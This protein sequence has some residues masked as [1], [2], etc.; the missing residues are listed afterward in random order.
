MGGDGHDG[1]RTVA[2]ED[3]FGDPHGD[4]LPGERIHGIGAG[5]HARHRLAG[6]AFA[7]GLLF[8]LLQIGLH[9]L[10]LRGRG[11]FLHPFALRSQDHEGHAEDG[12]GPGGEDGDV[13]GNAV[14]LHLEHH[15]GALGLADPVALHLL[16][17][18]GPVQPLQGI[19]EPAGIGRYAELPL[20]HLLLE[21][22]MAAALGITVLHLIIGENRTEGRA[23]VHGGFALVGDAVVHQ[24][25]G[26]L[27][28]REC[29]PLLG[30]ELGGIVVRRIHGRGTA[31]FE[32]GHEFLD[33]ARF[34]ESVVVP[35]A[36]HL[37]EGPL[38]PLVIVRI[39]GTELTVP[40]ER[41]TDAVQLAAITRHILVGGFLRMLAGLDGVLLRREA[42]GVI[43][44]RMQDVEALQALV[45]GEDIA[46][47][48]AQRM[49]YMQARS[50]RIREHVQDIVFGLPA[51]RFR[52]E[53]LV[54]GPPL[55][56][57]FLNLNKVVFHR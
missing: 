29:I 37:Q 35:A 55:L 18:I 4:L 16:Q 11:E 24:D 28:V 1:T 40:V 6:D 8:D 15:L 20:G 32:S 19:Q 3:I 13:V 38:G 39:R 53:G 9:G 23:P 12:I 41:E 52:P 43:T 45:T 42:E 46:G 27:L 51:V 21:Y 57:P 14:A 31:L 44:H 30:S 7:L 34:L 36:E 56:P 17:G 2:C 25:I 50:R 48:V 54:G 33:G 10:F 47:N 5:E 49:S 22:R 26:F